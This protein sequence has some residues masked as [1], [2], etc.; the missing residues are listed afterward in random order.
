MKEYKVNDKTKGVC[1]QC[2]KLVEAT[3]MI[4]DVP[5]SEGKI[6]KNIL[7]SVCDECNSVIATPQ[8]SAKEIKKQ[9]VD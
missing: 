4:R 6:V 3:M 5:S 7:V 2:K 8:Q 9:L 1:H